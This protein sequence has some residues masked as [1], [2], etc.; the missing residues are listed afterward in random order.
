MGDRARRHEAATPEDI[1]EM[2]RLVTEAMDAGALGF[3]TGRITVHMS[4]TGNHVP[5]TFAT[6][7]ELLALAKAMGE[8]RRR[9][10]FQLVPFGLVGD[11]V[12]PDHVGREAQLAE[13][14]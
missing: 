5:G 4:S 9:G 1:A 3:S 13:H 14:N 7:D 2:A 6:D 8:S 10:V 11:T 12:G